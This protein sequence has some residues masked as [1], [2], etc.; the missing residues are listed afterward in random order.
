MGLLLLGLATAGATPSPEWHPFTVG[1]TVMTDAAGDAAGE[2]DLSGNPTWS[3]DADGL[4][5]ALPLAALP[6]DEAGALLTGAWGVWIDVDGDGATAEV[7]LRLEGPGD[8]LAVLTPWAPVASADG[9]A[10]STTLDAAPLAAGRAGLDGAALWFAVDWATL[11][12]LG[13][14]AGPLRFAVV[15]WT[16]ALDPRVVADVAGSELSLAALLSDPLFA[17]GDGDGLVDEAETA[18]DPADADSDD[19]GL[20]DGEEHEGGTDPR[21]C[22]T[23]GDGLADGLESGVTAPLADTDP[24][25]GCFAADQGPDSRTDPTLADTDGG[26]LPDGVEDHSGD[27]AGSAW[28]TDPLSAADDVDDDR[29]GLADRLELECPVGGPGDDRDADG[30]DDTDEGLEDTD[31]DGLP[32]F[33]D[34]DD[35]QDGVPTAEEGDGDTDGDGLPDARDPDADND[36]LP[37]GEEG[38]GDVDCDGRPDFQD[39]QPSDGGC[40]DPDGDGLDNDAEA[41]C[42]SDP[43][44]ADTDGD[45]FSD[46]DEPCDQDRDCDLLPDRLDATAD[47]GLCGGPD[48]DPDDDDPCATADPND[49]FLDCGAF[50]GGACSTRSG[51]A[52]WLLAGLAAG[53]VVSR[54][55]AALLILA[56]PSAA[57][58][59]D[60]FDAQR[61]R[62][63]LDRG[64]FLAVVDARLGP[65]GLAAGVVE[66]VAKDPLVHRTDAGE[67][68]LVGLLATTDAWVGYTVRGVG[69]IAVD[70]PIHA[71]TSDYA[72]DG[73]RLGDVRASA[74]VRLPA[75]RA[76]RLQVGLEGWAA[77]P[78]GSERAWLGEP[79]VTGG[80]RVMVGSGSTWRMVANA[81]AWVPAP[82][83]LATLRRGPF[84]S[85][86]VGVSRQWDGRLS[87][88]GEADVDVPV[89]ALEETPGG[90]ARLGARYALEGG[91]ELGVAL[92]RGYLPGVGSPDARGVVWVDWVLP[93]GGG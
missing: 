6:V 18:T 77:F 23:D 74:R 38:T 27:G 3:A 8:T 82:V 60:E 17:D 30:F 91:F 33:C 78:T 16:D 72:P 21:A 75:D 13:A 50:R 36:G 28:E 19:D 66:S 57:L 73:V 5:L 46:P 41:A 92:G 2:V 10:V 88:F 34:E 26:G 35:D 84:L 54:R 1:G 83:D 62:P 48:P 32:A 39:A 59:Q 79:E 52:A 9:D 69:R 68:H 12:D 71:S 90:E 56:L 80:G 70:V 55:R 49:R 4:R 11:A 61:F 22:D 31:G 7:G 86:A 45:G 44:E 63:A 58:A 43:L 40:A 29:D 37:D 81:G 65:G 76:Q 25:A 53:L 89:T 24:D 42:G 67:R 47:A 93:P 15:T 51:E 87:L 85:G 64:R 14:G 20:T